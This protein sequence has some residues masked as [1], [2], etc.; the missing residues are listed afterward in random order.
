MLIFDFLYSKSETLE[1]KAQLLLYKEEH[2]SKVL[3]SVIN[4]V[5]VINISL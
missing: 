5:T 4:A 1:I 3:W 2:V